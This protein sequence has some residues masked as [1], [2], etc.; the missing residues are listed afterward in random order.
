MSSGARALRAR[1]SAGRA[2][3][4]PLADEGRACAQPLAAAG[5]YR[6]L[7]AYAGEQLPQ[8][9]HAVSRSYRRVLRHDRSQARLK[10]APSF[11]TPTNS[12][13]GC[14]CRDPCGVH[15]VVV[16]VQLSQRRRVRISLSAISSSSPSAPALSLTLVQVLGAARGLMLHSARRALMAAPCC[17]R[18]AAGRRRSST[19]VTES[20]ARISRPSSLGLRPPFAPDGARPSWHAFAM[21]AG[22]ADDEPQCAQ[23]L[24]TMSRMITQG[25]N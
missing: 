3:A 20:T 21:R 11:G 9:P 22:A 6:K 12:F 16:L 1:R 4:Q 24:Q 14:G 23:V 19:L 7:Q 5:G 17:H 25:E 15:K 18:V 8:L 10:L 13:R 2:C